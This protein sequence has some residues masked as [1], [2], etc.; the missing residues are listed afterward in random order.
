MQMHTIQKNVL[1]NKERFSSVAVYSDFLVKQNE[2]VVKI[3]LNNFFNGG[4]R[5]RRLPCIGSR[6]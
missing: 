1:K 6:P 5:V 3:F 2:E 4:R